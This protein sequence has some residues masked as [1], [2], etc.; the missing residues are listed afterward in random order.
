M[1]S[2]HHVGSIAFCVVRIVA[3]A[4]VA[5]AVAVFVIVA[6]GFFFQVGGTTEWEGVVVINSLVIC[7]RV[8]IHTRALAG[9]LP[10]RRGR[11]PDRGHEPRQDRRKREVCTM[12]VVRTVMILVSLPRLRF[13][14]SR[15][16]MPC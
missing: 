15:S 8:A 7:C 10:E 16:N 9:A 5:A 13:A 4:A 2:C 12:G 1:F 14:L 11:G 6:G 3:V